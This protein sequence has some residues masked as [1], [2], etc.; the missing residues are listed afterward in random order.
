V[1]WIDVAKDRDKWRDVVSE[2]INIQVAR[3]AEN[4]FTN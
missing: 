2:K 3:R 4:V 1:D